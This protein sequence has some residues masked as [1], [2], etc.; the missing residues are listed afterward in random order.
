MKA[1]GKVELQWTPW[2]VSHHGPVIDYMANCNGPCETVN[3]TTLSWF[4]VDQ[5]GLVDAAASGGGYWGT[6][7][8]QFSS[9]NAVYTFKTSLKCPILQPYLS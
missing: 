6:D 2:P 5:V 9:G 4:K 7:G 1:G 3:K 8:K